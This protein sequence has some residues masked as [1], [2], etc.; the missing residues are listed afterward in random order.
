MNKIHLI[1]RILKSTKEQKGIYNNLLIVNKNISKEKKAE[2][3]NANK[4]TADLIAFT[5]FDKVAKT[6]S[7]YTNKNDIVGLTGRLDV[8]QSFDENGEKRF[9]TKV[10]VESVD[11]LP[12]SNFEE[13]YE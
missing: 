1:G 13:Y 5:A 12:Q 6:L 3:E 4:P 10:I 9:Y 7:E 11:L 2:L 8:S